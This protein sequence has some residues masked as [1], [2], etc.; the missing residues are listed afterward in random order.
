MWTIFASQ[1]KAKA[2]AGAAREDEVAVGQEDVVHLEAGAVEEALGVT[3]VAE[4]LEVA[5]AQEGSISAVA[6]VAVAEDSGEV[7]VVIG[8]HDIVFM[9]ARHEFDGS[10]KP[11]KS[12]WLVVRSIQQTINPVH[13]VCRCQSRYILKSLTTSPSARWQPAISCW[14]W[15][16]LSR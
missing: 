7:V 1:K 14:G 9:Y 11:R 6:V 13:T 10:F 5:E 2:E 15:R 4:A 8:G 12:V 3:V 16:L